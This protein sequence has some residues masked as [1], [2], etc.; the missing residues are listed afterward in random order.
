MGYD[1][2]KLTVLF[3]SVRKFMAWRRDGSNVSFRSFVTLRDL[4]KEVGNDAARFYYVMRKSEQHIDFD[5]DLAV[6]QS[7]DNAVYYIQYARTYLSYVRKA[8][9]TD[10]IRRKYCSPTCN[11]LV[12]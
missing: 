2:K 8:A 9:S 6:S 1:S 4:R 11:S 3:S 7:K 12:S 10:L 5:L